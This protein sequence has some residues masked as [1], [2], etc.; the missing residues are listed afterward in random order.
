VGGDVFD[1]SLRVIAWGGRLIIIGFASGRVQQIP[2]NL[3]LV[4]NCDAIGFFW[5]SYRS[6]RFDIV[7]RSFA[8]LFRWYEAGRLKPHISHRLDLAEAGRAIALLRDRKATGKVVLTTG[9]D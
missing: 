2:A 1:A 6:R 7:Q 3:L 8:E 4:K 5:G 9:R